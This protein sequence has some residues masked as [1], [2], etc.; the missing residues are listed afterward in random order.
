MK[1][2]GP[3][4]HSDHNADKHR[5]NDVNDVRQANAE[6]QIEIA[7]ASE[8]KIPEAESSMPQEVNSC[9]FLT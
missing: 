2:G 1:I 7:A 5:T 3:S 6:A 4:T 9:G 8:T